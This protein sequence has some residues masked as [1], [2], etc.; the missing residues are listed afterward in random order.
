MREARSLTPLSET[1]YEAIEAAVMETAR[2]RWFM[3][4]Y[5]R[6]NRHADTQQILGAIHRIERVVGTQSA[7]PMA[8]SGIAEATALIA[9]LRIDLERISGRAEDRASGLAARI[10]A[11]AGTILQATESIQEV[12]WNL[13]EAG[14]GENLCDKLDQHA[15]EIAAA[16]AIVD[17][18]VQQ[19][20]KIADTI[21]MLDS[22]LR[23]V[24]GLSSP[25]APTE[26]FS[27]PLPRVLDIGLAEAPPYVG[28]GDVE[29]IEIDDEP[30]TPVA[31]GAATTGLLGSEPRIGSILDL[32]DDVVFDEP[33]VSYEPD[34]ASEPLSLGLLAEP[35]APSSPGAAGI[36]HGSEAG[37]REIDAMPASRKLAYFA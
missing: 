3:A 21:A 5:A 18:T 34:A 1:D 32:D 29:I 26:P 30:V 25:S 37:L 27:A 6:R 10:D 31:S 7:Q 8:E 9:D 12:A 4:E 20:D 22:S 35:H 2:G 16:T 17:G 11:V 33:D 36:A 24:S 13:R 23:A 14:A 28:R 15:A 19:I